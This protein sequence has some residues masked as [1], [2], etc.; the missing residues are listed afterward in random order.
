MEAR[1]MYDRT[2]ATGEAREIANELVSR[3]VAS[4]HK[5]QFDSSILK[6]KIAAALTESARAAEE[7]AI[8]AEQERCAK[9]VCEHCRNGVAMSDE[10]PDFHR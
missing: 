6:S 9:L 3:W 7:R 1:L 10:L 2:E 8:R 4:L 5:A